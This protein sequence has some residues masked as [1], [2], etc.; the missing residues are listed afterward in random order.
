MGRADAISSSFADEIYSKIVY[1]GAVHHPL[2][3]LSQDV[4]DRLL[5]TACP[6]RTASRVF[7]TGWL[8]VSGP[9]ERARD[10]V[11]GLDML[12]SM[13]LCANVPTQHA[14]QGALGGYQSITDYVAPGGNLYEQRRI[15]HSML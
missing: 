11:E 3:S 2:G 9:T 8:V 5:S 12:A 10:Y 4:T 15:A 14:I 13:R 1:D 6:R 7:R